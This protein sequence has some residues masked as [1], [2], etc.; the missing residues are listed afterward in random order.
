MKKITTKP[1]AVRN[2]QRYLR[3]LSYENEEIPPIP[4]DG[5]FDTRTEEA[6]SVYQR[7]SSLPVTGRADK[8]TWDSLFADYS[9]LIRQKDQ[10][11]VPDF[12]PRVPADYETT[13]GERSSFITLLQWILGELKVIYDTIPE[14]YMSGIYDDAT[15]AAV[16][17][18]QRIH[19]LPQ[20]GRVN[21]QVWNRMTEEYNQ[22][23]T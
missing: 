3:R 1:D 2:L 19:R 11:R 5:T 14:P 16:L 13:L 20:N 6:L 7:I 4:V 21:R 23:G 17:E 15:V 22:Y 12:F 9:R 8:D 10:K 18:F